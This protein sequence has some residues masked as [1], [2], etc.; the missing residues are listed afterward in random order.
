M[1]VAREVFD[2]GEGQLVNISPDDA[3]LLGNR[4]WAVTTMRVVDEMTGA[5]PRVPLTVTVTPPRAGFTPRA[6]DDGL[7]GLVAIP[8]HVFPALNAQAYDVSYTVAARR[9]VEQQVT[10]DFL[11]DVTFPNTFTPVPLADLGLHRAPVTVSGRTVLLNGGPP[12]PIA[13]ATIRVTGIWRTP[14]PA[15][16]AVPADPPNVVSLHPPL[17][18]PRSAA[19][20]QL[21]VLTLT[22]V[23]N[24]DK[25][26]VEAAAAGVTTLRL[27][28]RVNLAVGNVLAVEADDVDRLEYMEIQAI[29]GGSTPD[30]AATVTLL[31]PLA[32]GHPREV[33]VRR[34]TAGV[35]GVA[36]AITVDAI[37]GDSCLFLNNLNGMAT[38]NQVRIF[39]G[40]PPEIHR[41]RLFRATSNAGGYYR[42]PPLSRVAQLEITA[43][44]APRQATVI[45]APDY[46][47][48]GNVLN[49]GLR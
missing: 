22:P 11:Q 29:N 38:A 10:A 23:A 43:T 31:H 6:A 12:T 35:P 46:S 1:T 32:F 45:F 30:Q 7:V 42:L 26:L 3:P 16:A 24:E 25:R 13:G 44:S 5:P 33:V 47:Q 21:Q 41:V 28:D 36:R 8:Q 18:R 27:S 34:M 39:G 48:D 17:Y 14:P 4:W 15:T 19:A 2:L 37:D 20:G 9:Y 49:L 40:G